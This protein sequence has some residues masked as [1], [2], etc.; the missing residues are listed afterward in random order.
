M[1]AI[2]DSQLLP[3]G[4]GENP[5]YGLRYGGSP[6]EPPAS[7]DQHITAVMFHSP[8]LS[9]RTQNS[10]PCFPWRMI[11]SWLTPSWTSKGVCCRGLLL[12][13]KTSLVLLCLVPIHRGTRE[14]LEVSRHGCQGKSKGPHRGK[15]AVIARITGMSRVGW[16]EP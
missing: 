12:L 14:G 1:Q 15:W 16:V 2:Y 9:S 11:S 6:S 13:R 7:N 10:W 4:G 5:S 3:S 8:S